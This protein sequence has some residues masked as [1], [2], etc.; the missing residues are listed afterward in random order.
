MGLPQEVYAI[1]DLGFN[2]RRI[3][4][5]DVISHK[6]EKLRTS[7]VGSALAVLKELEFITAKVLEVKVKWPRI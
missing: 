3:E 4:V 2:P 1:G 7:S 5:E 6:V